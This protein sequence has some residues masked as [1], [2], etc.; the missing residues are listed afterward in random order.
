MKRSC[1]YPNTLIP[2]A[3]RLYHNIMDELENPPLS[4][5]DEQKYHILRYLTNFLESKESELYKKIHEDHY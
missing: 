1:Q 5:T 2:I 3:Q 4:Y